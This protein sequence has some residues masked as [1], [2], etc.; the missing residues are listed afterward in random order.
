MVT[1]AANQAGGSSMMEGE[2]H[3]YMGDIFS[4]VQGAVPALDALRE[5]G[6]GLKMV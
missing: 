5:I 3:C 1:V 2:C 4:F 6:L